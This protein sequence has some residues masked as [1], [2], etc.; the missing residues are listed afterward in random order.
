MKVIVL[1]VVSDIM[2]VT[3]IGI[4]VVAVCVLMVNVEA[5]VA[6]VNE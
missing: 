2:M 5:V 1:V 4:V 6:M 3:A